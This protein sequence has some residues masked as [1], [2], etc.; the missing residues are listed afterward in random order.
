[1]ALSKTF[2][3]GLSAIDHFLPFSSSQPLFLPWH[4]FTF[5]FLFLS[6]WQL[7]YLLIYS[8]FTL[9]GSLH[10]VLSLFI[11]PLYWTM[12]SPSEKSPSATASALH[13]WI[14]N[15]SP[16]FSFLC[17]TYISKNVYLVHLIG[18]ISKIIHHLFLLWVRFSFVMNWIV[19][20]S[21]PNSISQ[22]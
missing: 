3:T 22:L 18:N 7:V 21:F 12:L 4:Y 9:S 1:M 14:I 10:V 19:S 11:N 16:I 20:S 13:W 15:L 8:S 2:L 6:F 17:S 5:L